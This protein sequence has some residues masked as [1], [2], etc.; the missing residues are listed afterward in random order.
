[1]PITGKTVYLCLEMPA[2]RSRVE[3]IY[4]LELFRFNGVLELIYAYKKQGYPIRSLIDLR[5]IPVRDYC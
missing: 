2:G 1:M 4:N 5:D 3:S